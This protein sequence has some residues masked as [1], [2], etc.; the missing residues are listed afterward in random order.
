MVR[1]KAE[2]N[3]GNWKRGEGAIMVTVGLGVVTV[4]TGIGLGNKAVP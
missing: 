4:V 1:G 2:G 3:H